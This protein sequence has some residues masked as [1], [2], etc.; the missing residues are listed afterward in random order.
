MCGITGIVYSDPDR[1][2]DAE[3]VDGMKRIINILGNEFGRYISIKTDLEPFNQNIIGAVLVEK[4]L[5][6]F[7]IFYKS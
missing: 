2:V 4:Q 5:N 6:L 1:Y 3:C 7:L